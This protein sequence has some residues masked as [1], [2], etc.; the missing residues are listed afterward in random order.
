MCVLSWR[1]LFPNNHQISG[2]SISVHTVIANGRLLY[3]NHTTQSSSSLVQ[4]LPPLT[5]NFINRLRNYF[6]LSNH[7]ISSMQD[8]QPSQKYAHVQC[9]ITII[10][11]P[12]SNNH[13]LLIHILPHQICQRPIR[14]HQLSRRTDKVIRNVPHTPKKPIFHDPI[15]FIHPYVNTN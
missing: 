10:S 8:N 4:P 2:I 1:R 13:R 14:I 3:D 9:K 7:G 11:S 12:C 5:N 6:K 15:L